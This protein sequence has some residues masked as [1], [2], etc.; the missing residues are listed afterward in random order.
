MTK[1]DTFMNTAISHHGEHGNWVW[2]NAPQ[3]SH[4]A[5]C[6]AFVWTC[7]KMAGVHNVIIPYTFSARY[8]CKMTYEQLHGQRFMSPAYG[9]STSFNPRRGDL[10]FYRW[11]NLI[12]AE[13]WVANHVGIVVNTTGDTVNTIEGNVGGGGNAQNIV[14]YRHRAKTYN[15]ILCYIRPAWT[16]VDLGQP[17]TG[18]P[19][20]PEDPTP[21]QGSTLII[22]GWDTV[23]P[24]TRNDA[25]IREV[26]YVNN[27]LSVVPSSIRLSEVNY[28]SG[29]SKL[30]TATGIIPS[31]P[32]S[33]DY[34][35]DGLASVPRAV[36]QQLVMNGF[37]MGAAIGILGN[38]QRESAFHP[39]VINPNGGASGLCQWYGDRCTA[40]KRFVGPDWA[41]NVTGQVNYLIHEITDVSYFHNKLYD[42]LH[43]CPNSLA[44]AREAADTF[45]HW[46]ESLD[47]YTSTEAMR[48]VV[49]AEEQW[50]RLVQLT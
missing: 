19:E 40:M 13:W 41:T 39:E 8:M 45:F 16:Q 11:E 23:E 7:A 10:I 49:F 20:E 42:F 27:G 38:M 31:Y 4:G 30:I 14:D 28:T 48:R 3:P 12:N 37:T 21:W 50:Q 22:P 44:G 46:Y 34:V 33:G 15:K 29:L 24:N 25:S 9:G 1:L 2:E 5:W 47:T 26:G 43:T 6:A 32:S 17:D 18:E 35:L 36:V